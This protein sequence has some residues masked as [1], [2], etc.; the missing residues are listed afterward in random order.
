MRRRC[1]V[2]NC[3][4]E[5]AHGGSHEVLSGSRVLGEEGEVGVEHTETAGDSEVAR[6]VQLEGDVGGFQ[7]LGFITL[8]P[9]EPDDVGDLDVRQRVVAFKIDGFVV[10]SFDQALFR[11]HRLDGRG[12]GTLDADFLTLHR[13]QRGHFAILGDERINSRTT[14]D[15]KGHESRVVGT[16][17]VDHFAER[18]AR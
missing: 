6:V 9:G 3:V 1:W 17:E 18:T 14:L 12:N 15:S 13:R 11:Q 2:G 5:A 4:G 7:L 16:S 10:D 8:E